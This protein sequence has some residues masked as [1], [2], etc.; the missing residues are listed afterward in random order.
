MCLICVA[1]FALVPASRASDFT[2][3][4]SVSAMDTTT[5]PVSDTSVDE[6]TAKS[7]LQICRTLPLT[8]VAPTV[9]LDPVR[10]AS[11]DWLLSWGSVSHRPTLF[12]WRIS[13]RL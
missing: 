10:F 12:D 13:L 6:S 8:G 1:I 4:T 5:V 2:A 9:S 3:V 7:V 11:S